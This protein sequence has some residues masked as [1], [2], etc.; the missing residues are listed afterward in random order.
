MEAFTDNRLLF[1]LR[2]PFIF[3]VVGPTMSGKTKFVLDLIER[4]KEIVSDTF[5]KVIYI[6]TEDQPLYEE[7]KK[8]IHMLSLQR[9]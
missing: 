1:Q 5:D 2:H 7:F 9:M 4:Q 6:Y 3:T 8:Y